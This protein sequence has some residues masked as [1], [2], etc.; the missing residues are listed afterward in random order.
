M[1]DQFQF[2]TDDQA[3]PATAQPSGFQ[4]SSADQSSG[5][6]PSNFYERVLNMEPPDQGPGSKLAFGVAQGAAK[7]INSTVIGAADL[8]NKMF[9][10][11]PFGHDLFQISPETRQ[12]L[13]QPNQ[14]GQGTGKFLEQAAEF[15]VPAGEAAKAMEGAPLA[16]R[17]LAQSGISG[18]VSAV[19]S[20]GDA[21]TTAMG[22]GMGGLG[23][24]TKAAVP[25]IRNAAGE[26]APNQR[27]YRNAFAATPN[28]LRDEVSPIMHRLVKDGIMPTENIQGMDTVLGGKLAE[29]SDKYDALPPDMR[30]RE[31]NA[32]DV[33]NQLKDKMSKLKIGEVTLSGNEPLVKAIQRE[34]GDIE[35]IGAQNPSGNLKFTD[36][37]KLRNNANNQTKFDD[38][39]V[40]KT[41]QKQLGDIYRQSMDKIAPE[42][43]QLNKDWALYTGL[44]NLTKSNM[45]AGRGTVPSRFTQG[46]AEGTAH[47]VGATLGA[48]AG[49]HMAGPLG[50]FVG[51]MIGS[52]AWPKISKPVGQALQNLADSG[53]LARA[54]A[55]AK[56]ALQGALRVGNEAAVKRMIGAI[57]QETVRDTFT[58]AGR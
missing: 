39:E 45:D 9:T 49:E 50:G 57:G 6:T 47:G 16:A 44:K 7:G 52:A 27:N 31:I 4:Y 51:G 37:E 38:P 3:T 2:S 43:T 18:G 12:L 48:V 33:I 29:L 30:S 14:P 5:P 15:A 54:S 35:M 20:G 58:P 11:G 26:L 13:T 17:L 19:Q 42:T 22:A 53:A 36:L 21:A 10:T 40:Q 28:Q 1:P 8:A 32:Y 24:L 34:I 25:A 46:I 56:A 23:E 41:F 55:P